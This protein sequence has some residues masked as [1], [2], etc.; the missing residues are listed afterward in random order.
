MKQLA[1]FF[2]EALGNQEEYKFSWLV[3]DEDEW[4]RASEK[5]GHTLEEIDFCTVENKSFEKCK[6]MKDA[7]KLA[8]RRLKTL[9][10]YYYA[11]TVE[12]PDGDIQTVTLEDARRSNKRYEMEDLYLRTDILKW[13]KDGSFSVKQLQDAVNDVIKNKE[14]EYYEVKNNK[15]ER[16][17]L[18]DWGDYSRPYNVG[19]DDRAHKYA[20]GRMKRNKDIDAICIKSG[21]PGIS[22][23]FIEIVMSDRFLDSIKSG[24]I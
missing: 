1:D 8:T 5:A 18:F 16:C 3:F 4:Y 7:T 19:D 14:D 22:M 17:S 15:G 13:I 10:G 9:R 24:R 11:I 21:E 20:L 12:S 6:D 23:D 2:I